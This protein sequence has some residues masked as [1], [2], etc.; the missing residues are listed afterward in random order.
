MT[1]NE[2]TFQNLYETLLDINSEDDRK[3]DIVRFH[4]KNHNIYTV[5]ESKIAMDR[6]D[7][8]RVILNDNISTL[9][10]GHWRLNSN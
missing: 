3:R 7:D 8:K 6:N 2:I 10:I 1:E 5:K 4:H 9:A